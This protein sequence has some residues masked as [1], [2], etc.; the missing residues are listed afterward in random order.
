MKNIWNSIL[1]VLNKLNICEQRQN[2]NTNASGILLC[3]AAVAA[4]CAKEY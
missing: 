3:I 4:T 2:Y 1:L